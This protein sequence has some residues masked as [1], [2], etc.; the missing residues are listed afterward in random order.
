MDRVSA[1]A[2]PP[3]AVIGRGVVGL[4]IAYDAARRGFAVTSIGGSPPGASMVAAGMLAPVSEANFTEQ[5]LLR[6]NLRGAEVF[7][8]FISDLEV[9]SSRQVEMTKRGT[10][11]VALDRDDS[12]AL[13]RLHEFQVSLG[14]DSEW[15]DVPELRRLEPGLDPSVV[16]GVHARS[17][18]SVDPRLMVAALEAACERLGVTH[19]AAA[20]SRIGPVEDEVV[21]V[22]ERGEIRSGTVVIAAGCWSGEIPG[23]PPEVAKAV[24]PVKGQILRLRPGPAAAAGLSHVLRTDEVYLV[25]RPDGEV[26]VGA[27]VEER[28]WDTA[29]TAGGAF[30]LLRAGIEVFPP[31]RELELAE[32]SAGLR[33]GSRDNSPLIGRT[34]LPGIWCATGHHRNG[35]LLAPV[36]AMALVDSILTGTTAEQIEPFDPMRFR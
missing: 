16:A 10:L 22:T 20:V 11:M 26:V 8:E 28:G 29:P 7:P 3:L 4:S 24:R 12:R 2:A 34:S 1:R 25:P 9:A 27:T 23:A 32:V 6:L 31:L 17:D 13:T 14:L 30:D 15:L 21:M 33:P 18:L 36:T 19:V 35:V 5:E